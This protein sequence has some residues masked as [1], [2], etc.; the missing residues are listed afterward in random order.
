MERWCGVLVTVAILLVAAAAV[1]TPPPASIPPPGAS[2]VSASL[3]AEAAVSPIFPGFN[4]PVPTAPLTV[5]LNGSATGGTPPLRFAWTTGDGAA[6]ASQN[7]THA[8]VVPGTYEAVLA[9]TDNAGES[10]TSTAVSAATSTDGVHWVIG[11]ADPSLGSIPLTVHF[12]VTGMGQLPKSYDWRF[13]DGGSANSSETNH[14]YLIAGIYVASL[15]V[16]YSDGVNASYRMTVLALNGGPPVTHA[17]SSVVGLCYSDVWNRVSF[18]ARVAGGTPPYAFSW[19]FGEGNAT[20]TFQNPTYSYN[21]PAWSHL[22]NLTVTDAD[23]VVATTTVSVLVVPP[24]C[25]LKIV[26]PWL[27]IAMGLVAI[28]TVALVAVT[29]RKRKSRQPQQPP[30][31]PTSPP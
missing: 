10:S 28:A 8:Y 26:P 3:V 25:P 6:S 20:S 12:S 27:G 11:A 5:F 14:T 17:T 4:G 24:P 29:I 15:N 31:P 21:S 16:T 2:A 19:H 30:S 1:R 18:Q 13:G 22:S 23:G 7:T 9:V